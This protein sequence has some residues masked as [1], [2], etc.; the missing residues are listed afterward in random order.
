M[1]LNNPT[2]TAVAKEKKVSQKK[3]HSSKQEANELLRKFDDTFK[4]IKDS[5]P[6]EHL[7]TADDLPKPKKR[8]YTMP[9]FDSTRAKSIAKKALKQWVKGNK[10][11]FNKFLFKD[12][13]LNACG[14]KTAKMA[15]TAKEKKDSTTVLRSKFFTKQTLIAGVKNKILTMKHGEVTLDHLKKRLEKNP[16]DF[17]YFVEFGENKKMTAFMILG[18]QERDNICKISFIEI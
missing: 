16:D 8:V 7:G 13:E 1:I 2:T 12:A 15:M 6:S 4:A 3:N 10:T 9:M 18:L 17:Y 14:P 5:T 11:E